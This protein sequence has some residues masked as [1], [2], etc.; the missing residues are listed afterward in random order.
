LARKYPEILGAS[1]KGENFPIDEGTQQAK[2]ERRRASLVRDALLL[3]LFA[4]GE[5]HYPHE[6]R[7]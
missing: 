3:S 4:C 2:R 5:V 6:T 1:I 7:F